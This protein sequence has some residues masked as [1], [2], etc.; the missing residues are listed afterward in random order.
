M[1][2]HIALLCLTTGITINAAQMAKV[3]TEEQEKA[4]QLMFRLIFDKNNDYLKKLLLKYPEIVDERTSLTINMSKNRTSA[5][6]YAIKENNYEAF[7]LLLEYN[8]NPDI[9]CERDKETALM[10]A[11]YFCN[12]DCIKTLIATGVD[13]EFKNEHQKTALDLAKTGYANFTSSRS[14]YEEDIERYHQA[15]TD[16]EAERDI[17]ALEKQAALEEIQNFVT[18][19][20]LAAIVCG[21]AYGVLPRDLPKDLPKEKKNWLKSHCAI[22]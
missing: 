8:A 11:A 5:L 1:K 19:K 4:A 10:W 16:G 2:I 14:D 12:F 3:L 9:Q 20:D 7:C 22:Q 17:Y 15:I 18:V 21:Y 6:H 13:K